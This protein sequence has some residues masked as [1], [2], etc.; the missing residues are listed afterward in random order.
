MFV[1]DRVKALA[2]Q[3]PEWRDKEPFASLL[4]GDAKAALACG[5]K[6][7]LEVVAA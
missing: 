4:K 1:L 7:I 3:H 5:E 6:A 2:P